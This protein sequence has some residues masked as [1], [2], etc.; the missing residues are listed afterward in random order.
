MEKERKYKSCQRNTENKRESITRNPPVL[1]AIGAKDTTE[2]I[3]HT[4]LTLANQ[5]KFVET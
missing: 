1:T 2:S 4:K 3:A 5:Q